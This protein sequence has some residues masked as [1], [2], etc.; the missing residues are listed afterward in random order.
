MK[1]AIIGLGQRVSIR[2]PNLF[3]AQK[4]L[5]IVV[6]DE[7]E[8]AGAG[9]PYSRQGAS[10]LMLANIASI[11]IPVLNGVSYLDWLKILPAAHSVRL[12]H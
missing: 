5:E 3:A 1:I 8:W 6:Y 12:R 10:R 11:E 7:G 9:T 4:K 2:S